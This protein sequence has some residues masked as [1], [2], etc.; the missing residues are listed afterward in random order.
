MT[1]ISITTFYSTMANNIKKILNCEVNL[2]NNAHICNN[3]ID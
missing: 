3:L 2:T 1:Q